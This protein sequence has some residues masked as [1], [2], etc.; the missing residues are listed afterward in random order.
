MGTEIFF[1]SGSRSLSCV[2]RREREDRV[3]LS[4]QKMVR[5]NVVTE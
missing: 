2:V 4:G 3:G 5:E 1:G